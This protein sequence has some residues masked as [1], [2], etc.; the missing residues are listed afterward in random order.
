MDS[1]SSFVCN[2]DVTKSVGTDASRIPNDV[3]VQ[4]G[5]VVHFPIATETNDSVLGLAVGHNHLALSIARYVVG[6]G[7]QKL[8][9]MSV[10]IPEGLKKTAI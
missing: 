6:P 9:L 7:E 3:L 10:I 4:I 8:T 2:E 1:I 5:L